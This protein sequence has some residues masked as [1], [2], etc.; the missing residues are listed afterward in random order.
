MIIPL[1]KFWSL[2]VS[3]PCAPQ[4]EIVEQEWPNG[5]PLNEETIKRA[6]DL[7]LNIL[8][9]GAHLP[10]PLRREY[11]EKP[12]PGWRTYQEKRAPLLLEI[13]IKQF[14]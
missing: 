11:S 12:A 4:R 14:S 1:E 13:L 7:K 9:I 2:F 5:I 3:K 10:E 8:W 6:L